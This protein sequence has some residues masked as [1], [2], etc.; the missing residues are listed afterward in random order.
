M[1]VTSGC[2]FVWG[3]ELDGFRNNPPSHHHLTFSHKLAEKLEIPYVNLSVCGNGNDKIFRDVC[4]YLKSCKEYPTHM[5]VLWSHF[6]REEIAQISIEQEEKTRKVQRF[7]NMA[8]FSPMRLSTLD[9]K[10]EKA[11]HNLYCHYDPLRTGII[12]TVTYMTHLQWLCDMLG[13]KMIQ[14][15]MHK[16]MRMSLSLTLNPKN[17]EGETNWRLWMKFVLRELQ[18][19]KQTSR[20]GLPYYEDMY[21]MGVRLNDMKTGGH[22]GEETHDAYSTLLYHI[23]KSEFE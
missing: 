17:G 10:L 9:G 5:V 1:L 16:K 21:S 3:D 4:Q 18:S 23:F 7:Q 2:S 6:Q 12:H 19:L 22:P 20:V 8:Q 14:G 15:G 11:F 13:I